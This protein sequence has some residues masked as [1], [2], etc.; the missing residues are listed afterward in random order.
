M[1]VASGVEKTVAAV[2]ILFS[3]VERVCAPAAVQLGAAAETKIRQ[4]RRR[5]LANDHDLLE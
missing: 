5:V 3:L 1:G 4:P 2:M